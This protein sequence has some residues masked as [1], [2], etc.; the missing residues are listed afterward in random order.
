MKLLKALEDA[1]NKRDDILQRIGGVEAKPSV[2][3]LA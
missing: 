2:M 3:M 1:Q